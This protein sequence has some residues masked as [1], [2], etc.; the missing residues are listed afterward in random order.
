M[1]VTSAASG[2][3]G[4]QQQAPVPLSC[5]TLVPAISTGYPSSPSVSR[6]PSLA[7]AA[8]AVSSTAYVLS[9]SASRE[10]SPAPLAGQRV[11]AMTTLP[12]LSLPGAQATSAS[13]DHVIVSPSSYVAGGA[14][15]STYAPTKIASRSSS[16]LRGSIGHVQHH[17]QK[18]PQRN[19]QHLPQ[20]LQGNRYVSQFAP[21]ASAK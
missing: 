20:N 21:R 17:R 12:V 4:Y 14:S 13:A 3:T 8:G 2:A 10:P 9:P 19:S 15:V 11:M 16:P 7:P 18:S 5:Q 1:Q 6:E